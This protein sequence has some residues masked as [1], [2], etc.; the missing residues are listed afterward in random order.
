MTLR[1]V[2]VDD[3][4]PAR[5]RL[6]RMLAAHAD[7]TLIGEAADAAGAVEIL[8]RERPD[9]C[10]LDVQ[11]PA[12]DAF[13][14]LSR[15]RHV[16]RLIF[17]TAFDQYAVRAFDANALD[18]LL[19]PFSAARLSAAL[20]RARQSL[21]AEAAP[22]DVARLL[23]AIR[24]AAAGPLRIPGRRG[25]KIVLLDPAQIACFEAEDTL[26]YARADDGRY[27]VERPLAEL[28]TQLASTFFRIHRRY[29]V[30]LSL[31]GEIH[32]GEGATWEVTLKDA[33]RSALPLSRRQAQKLREIIPW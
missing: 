26:V 8:D 25:A 7:V 4:K 6:R 22:L 20:D 27:L 30:N 13:D 18:Y 29:L 5:D 17:T 19:K 2:I 32:P 9:L 3:E 12:G 14:V 24:P 16:P 15:L 31:I 28:E 23:E 11:M 21:R 1:A 33:K 10:F